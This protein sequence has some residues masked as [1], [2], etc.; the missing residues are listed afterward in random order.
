MTGSAFPF[1]D[2]VDVAL[3]SAGGSNTNSIPF[4]FI[5]LNFSLQEEEGP[6]G[7]ERVEYRV[8]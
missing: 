2:A 6:R 1:M 5:H 8:P 3:L 7:G 4:L